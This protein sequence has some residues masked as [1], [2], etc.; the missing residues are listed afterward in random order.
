MKQENNEIIE[1]S[2]AEQKPTHIAVPVEAAQMIFNY[3]KRQPFEE[4]E[5]I[6]PTIAN[7]P[8]IN[9]NTKETGSDFQ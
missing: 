6:I 4:V 9:L 2:I 3:L 1:T 8:G 7:A 5:M